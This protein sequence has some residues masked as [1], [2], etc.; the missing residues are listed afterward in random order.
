MG[1]DFCPFGGDAAVYYHLF[2]EVEGEFWRR[3]CL[4][5]A[6]ENR[7]STDFCSYWF[8]D[9]VG[10]VADDE[11]EEVGKRTVGVVHAAFEDGHSS[12]KKCS[13][14]LF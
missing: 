2:E 11:L 1:V 4:E 10:F 5:Y 13:V 7:V 6:V 8:A 12:P 3:G 9:L 14:V